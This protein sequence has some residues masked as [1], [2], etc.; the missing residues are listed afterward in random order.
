MA[1]LPFLVFS[2]LHSLGYLQQ[3][4]LPTLGY[5]ANGL[6]AQ[7]G[8]FRKAQGDRLTHSAANFEFL[9]ELFLFV[10]FITFRKGS[11]LPL[12]FYTTFIKLRHDDSPHTRAV[13]SRHEVMVDNLLSHPSLPPVIKQ[14]WIQI[15]DI[16]R[17]ASRFISMPGGGTATAA[18]KAK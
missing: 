11:F 3:I 1:L 4:L 9:T 14:V 6:P 5:P 2:L 8:A 13:V 17:T 7:I 12:I 18:K 10:R 16:L 15:K